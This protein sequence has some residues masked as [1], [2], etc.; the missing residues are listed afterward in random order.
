M[1]GKLDRIGM[2]PLPE[3]PRWAPT[4]WAVPS[5]GDVENHVWK[6][7]KSPG[8]HGSLQEVE[9][10]QRSLTQTQTETGLT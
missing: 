8:S 1:D 9:K 10:A 5:R 4:E 6:G 2:L 7:L 3:C